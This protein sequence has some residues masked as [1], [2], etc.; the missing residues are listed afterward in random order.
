MDRCIRRAMEK[1][2]YNIAFCIAEGFE[3]DFSVLCKDTQRVAAAIAPGLQIERFYIV[4]IAAEIAGV[5]A[6][7]DCNGRAAKVDRESLKKHFGLV[8]GM[9]AALVLREE[10]E[11]RLNYP[12]ETGY[13]EFVAVRKKFRR[14]SIASFMLRE[15][16]AMS[17]Y[18]DFVLD[19]TDVNMAALCCYTRLGFREFER[20]TEKHAKQKGYGAKIYMR[21][22]KAGE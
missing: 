4:E 8:K 16:M 1:D 11:G 10:F 14:N 9:I 7:A 20:I 12:Q 17:R 19:V 3:K 21:Y 15:S 2:R 6:I 22:E 5:M 13:I 18:K